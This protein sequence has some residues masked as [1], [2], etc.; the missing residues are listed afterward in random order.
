MF[1]HLRMLQP[2]PESRLFHANAQSG[3]R[4]RTRRRRSV[5][6]FFP[7]HDSL[8]IRHSGADQKIRKQWESDQRENIRVL[9]KER[10]ANALKKKRDKSNA[11]KS[12]RGSH[13]KT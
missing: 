2:R 3:L 10:L 5:G 13:S 7:D 9:G 1:Q 8:L 6:A 12:P 11:K 4:P